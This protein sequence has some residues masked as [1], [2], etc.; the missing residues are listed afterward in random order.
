MRY[1][2]RY[3][4]LKTTQRT[5]HINHPFALNEAVL[6]AKAWLS[7]K[8]GKTFNCLKASVFSKKVPKTIQRKVL[9]SLAVRKKPAKTLNCSRIPL[10]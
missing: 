7:A 6:S 2:L 4:L 10:K 8:P 9:H 5:K 1:T 3:L